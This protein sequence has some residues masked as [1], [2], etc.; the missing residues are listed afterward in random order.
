MT[1]H[2]AASAFWRMA[3]QAVLW[4]GVL[5]VFASGAIAAAGWRGRQ[6]SLELP[7]RS[8]SERFAGRRA[9]RAGEILDVADEAGLVLR[10]SQDV[11]ARQLSMLEMAIEPDLTVRADR[12]AFQDILGDVVHRAIEQSPCGRILLTAGRIGGFVHVAVSDDGPGTGG[13]IR[14]TRLRDAES[15]V[16]LQ[17]GSIELDARPGEGTTVIVRL[18]AG[19]TSQDATDPAGVSVLGRETSRANIAD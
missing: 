13:A 3:G 7:S 6:R 11:A 14:L 19:R 12:R 4:W 16:T 5:A 1:L 18:P 15:L 10:Q 2:Q 17:G 8:L 9:A